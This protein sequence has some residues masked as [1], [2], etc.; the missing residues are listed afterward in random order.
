MNGEAE[1]PEGVEVLG[2]K[3][4]TTNDAGYCLVLYSKNNSGVPH[5][6]IVYKSDSRENLYYEMTELLLESAK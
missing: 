5:I 1:T 2:G 3:T 4:G 6:S